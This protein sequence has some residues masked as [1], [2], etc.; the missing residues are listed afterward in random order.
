MSN[1]A[2]DYYFLSLCLLYPHREM[3]VQLRLLA[4]QAGPWAKEV[5]VAFET[6]SLETLQVEHTRLFVNNID[7]APCPPYQ[8]A[9][10]DG[11]LMSA[12]TALAAAFYAEWGVAQ[13]LETA[14]YLPV[15]LQFIAWLMELAAQSAH[16]EPIYRACRRFEAQHLRPWLAR[17]AADLQAQTTLDC[18]RLV[19]SRLLRLAENLSGSAEL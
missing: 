10:V 14:D 7:G 2:A 13:A 19:A 17:F 4:E 16:P 5:A 15:Q 12:T 3:A 18:Y 11:H 1:S 8:S 6:P 9:Y